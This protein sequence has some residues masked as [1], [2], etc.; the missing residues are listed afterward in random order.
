[1]ANKR[2]IQYPLM[3]EKAV[4]LIEKENKLAFIVD[5]KSNK[6]EVKNA[7]EKLYGVKVESINL[8]ITPKGLKKAYVRLNPD[9]KASDLAIKLGIL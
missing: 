5:N 4:N 2:V 1:M 9:Y 6:T 7:I 3:T 8:L